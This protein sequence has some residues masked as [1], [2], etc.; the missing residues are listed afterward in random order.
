[1]AG[2]NGY[3]G[4]FNL[5]TNIQDWL[6]DC[7]RSSMTLIKINNVDN[8]CKWLSLIFQFPIMSL[9]IHYVVTLGLRTSIHLM[10]RI[11]CYS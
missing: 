10:N 7:D 3:S 4:G 2:V 1:M 5:L 6:T 8:F 9:L 11:E